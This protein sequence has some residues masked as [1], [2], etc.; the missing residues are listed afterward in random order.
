[1]DS[2]DINAQS[3]NTQNVQF[4]ANP[5]GK[6]GNK[7]NFHIIVMIGLIILVIVIVGVSR[8]LSVNN[9][10]FNRTETNDMKGE[11]LADVS[12]QKIYR[13]DVVKLAKEQYAGSNFDK[14]ILENFFN[15]LVE[16]KI[17]D[18]EAPKLGI[19]VTDSEINTSI[20]QMQQ[21]TINSTSSS[22]TAN[23]KSSK[24]LEN[25]IRYNLLKDKITAQVVKSIE[26]YTLGYWLIPI[27]QTPVMTEA[28]KQEIAIVRIEGKKALEEGLVMIKNGS[29]FVDTAKALYSKYP[30]LQSR[31]AINDYYF[32]S[33]KNDENN[34]FLNTPKVYILNDY[35]KDKS[36]LSVLTNLKPGETTLY[37][38]EDGSGGTIFKAIS[39]SDGS[40][41]SYDLWLSA[42]KKEMVKI[43]NPI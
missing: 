24:S 30:S 10:S 28:K 13:G 23:L 1:M 6:P 35:Q 26:V 36:L 15:L 41:D 2:Q 20:N 29:S 40:Y 42:K 21:S 7:K 12:G 11:L 27:D 19:I 22:Q 14:K 43:Y 31:L 32:N 5:E 17:L 38:P 16:R 3:V 34:Y 25:T 18:I 39:I 9:L 8:Y 4:I 33:F 37:W